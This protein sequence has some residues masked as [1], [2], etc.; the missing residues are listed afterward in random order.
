MSNIINFLK[1]KQNIFVDISI[2][3]A[4][5]SEDLKDILTPDL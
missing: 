4:L 1:L 5:I 2:S 3:K